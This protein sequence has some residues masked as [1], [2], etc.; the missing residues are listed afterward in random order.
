MGFSISPHSPE[1]YSLTL[2]VHTPKLV[3]VLVGV[4]LLGLSF[5]SRAASSKIRS[6]APVRCILNILERLAAC[7]LK[8]YTQKGMACSATITISSSLALASR[9][10]FLLMKPPRSARPAWS[11]TAAITLQ[12]TSI[13]KKSMASTCISTVPHIFHTSPASRLG[14]R[15]S[16]RRVQQLC[17]LPCCQ[18]TRTSCTTCRST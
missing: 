3:N 11:S 16:V 15:Q 5:D 13:R 2:L 9:A 8:R 17:E 14:L 18:S 10:P 1:S 4:F 6:S 12:A 7:W